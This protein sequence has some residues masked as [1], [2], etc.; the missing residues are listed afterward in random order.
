MRGG[1][2]TVGRPFPLGSLF[3]QLNS[4][5]D[6][7]VG[8]LCSYASAPPDANVRQYAFG[9]ATAWMSVAPS[10]QA[11]QSTTA[12][13]KLWTIADPLPKAGGVTAPMYGP[14]WAYARAV[15]WSSYVAGA[16]EP[17][18]GY[19]A[20]PT[21]AWST[22]YGPS[23]PVVATGSNGYPGGVSTPYKAVSPPNFVAPPAARSGVAN[24]RVLNV[25]LL[26]CPV[27][28]GALTTA[29]VLGVGKFMMTVPATATSLHAEFGGLVAEQS[30]GGTVEL[31]P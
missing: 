6:Q 9:A 19:T 25:A 26:S 11:A 15:P 17:A 23:A 30:L 31:Y 10:S 22:L 12:G 7:Y 13:G 24:R 4:R 21:S 2:I 27:D 8:S 5:F 29:T 18:S 3:N 28:P 20:F 14:L 1:T 16:A